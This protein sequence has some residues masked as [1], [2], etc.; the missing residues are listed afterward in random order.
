MIIRSGDH[1]S[2]IQVDGQTKIKDED[3][4]PIT[5]SALNIGDQVHVVGRVASDDT[6][7]ATSVN[8]LGLQTPVVTQ[9]SAPKQEWIK[10]TVSST[11]TIISRNIK[12]MTVDGEITVSVPHGIPIEQGDTPLSVHDIQ[13][14]MVVHLIGTFDDN[15]QLNAESITVDPTTVP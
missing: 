4:N 13:K 11:A 7:K 8:R 15:H 9:S 1:N 10:G 14:G 5:E 3:G 2:E 12:V 6:I